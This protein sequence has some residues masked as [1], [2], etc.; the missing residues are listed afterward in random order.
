MHL[1]F[2][3]VGPYLNHLP[4]CSG[5]TAAVEQQGQ[6]GLQ[7]HLASNKAAMIFLRVVLAFWCYCMLTRAQGLPLQHFRQEQVWQQ[8]QETHLL[9]PAAWQA[10]TCST[11]L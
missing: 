8:V 7:L 6:A 9:H 1:L 11:R 4:P 10:Q 2:L 5:P 3:Y